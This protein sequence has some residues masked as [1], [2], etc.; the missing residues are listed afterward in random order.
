MVLK[1]VEAAHGFA[2]AA[3][4]CCLDRGSTPV[5]QI[6]GGE[7]EEGVGERRVGRRR[8]RLVDG[9]VVRG[10]ERWAKRRV[11]GITVRRDIPCVEGSGGLRRE[12]ER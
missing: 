8:G 4:P 3:P 7:G 1:E 12:M 9:S 11:G 10:A 6:H 5:Q 2:S